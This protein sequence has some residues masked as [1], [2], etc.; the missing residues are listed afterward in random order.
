MTTKFFF[1]KNFLAG[2]QMKTHITVI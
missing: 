2:G 1:P